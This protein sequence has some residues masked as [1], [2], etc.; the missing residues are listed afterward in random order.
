MAIVMASGTGT[1]SGTSETAVLSSEPTSG[2][3]TQGLG[4]RI[5]GI[6]SFTGNASASTVTIKVRQG[7]G[8]SGTTV[9]TS[10]AVTVAA[11]AVMTVPY[12]CQ[13]TTQGTNTY[14]I[15]A[16]FSGAPAASGAVSA[17]L[18]ITDVAYYAD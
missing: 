5:N 12:D 6:V 7:V 17:T 14:T 11:G 1:V 13:D 16:T 18:A 10:G 9:Y 4:Y 3:D 15:T 2:T 8:T